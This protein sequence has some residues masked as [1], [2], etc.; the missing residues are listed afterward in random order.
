VQEISAEKQKKCVVVWTNQA[1]TLAKKM[2]TPKRIGWNELTLPPSSRR[3]HFPRFTVAGIL[4]A[5]LLVG[6]KPDA[7][8]KGPK[9]LEPVAHENTSPTLGVPLVDSAAPAGFAVTNLEPTP[10]TQNPVAAPL[11][12]NTPASSSTPKKS[13]TFATGPTKEYVVNKGD[14]LFKIAR[15]NG[16]TVNALTQANPKLK[17]TKLKS[18]QKVHI[19]AAG[20]GSTGLGFAEPGSG[21][22]A[23]GATGGNVHVVKAGETLTQIAKQHGTTVKGLQAANQLKV[24]RLFVGQKIKLPAPG[25]ASTTTAPA[26]PAAKVSDTGAPVVP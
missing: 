3:S 21:P 11:T 25:A 14:T 1:K 9:G 4:L 22:N 20:S 13:A 19:P 10:P 8:N 5:A 15:A 2:N 7:A 26:D 12:N 23:T 6:C 24:T 16:V 18:G 17:T